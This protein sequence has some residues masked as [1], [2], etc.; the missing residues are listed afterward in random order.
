[1]TDEGAGLEGR[2]KVEGDTVDYVFI[3][4]HDVHVE[5]PIVDLFVCT[6]SIEFGGGCGES[7][8]YVSNLELNASVSI[9]CGHRMSE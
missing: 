2:A 7:L 8:V 5:D 4:G 9:R 1:V 3:A 6:V